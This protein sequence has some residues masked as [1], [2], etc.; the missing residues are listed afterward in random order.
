MTPNHTE[1]EAIRQLAARNGEARA[2]QLL[3]VNHLTLARAA[4]GFRLRVASHQ[5]IVQR[6]TELGALDAAGAAQPAR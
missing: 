3:G 6:L 5:R 4:A 2:A 1:A